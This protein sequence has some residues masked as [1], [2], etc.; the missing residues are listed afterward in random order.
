MTDAID[1]EEL[2]EQF[3][4]ILNEWL[5]EDELEEINRRNST[6]EYAG[7]CATHD[8]CDPNQAMSDAL[9]SIGFEFAPELCESINAAWDLATANNFHFKKRSSNR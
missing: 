7:S 8:F 6:P 5:T 1:T 3:C 9:E 2:A 4:L